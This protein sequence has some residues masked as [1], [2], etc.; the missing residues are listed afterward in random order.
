MDLPKGHKVPR[1]NVST[2]KE[3]IYTP[4][5]VNFLLQVERIIWSQPLPFPKG[6]RMSQRRNILTGGPWFINEFSSKILLVNS[7]FFILNCTY[8]KNQASNSL[9]HFY[10]N[11]L[12]TTGPKFPLYLGLQTHPFSQERTTVTNWLARSSAKLIEADVTWSWPGLW[13]KYPCEFFRQRAR[14]TS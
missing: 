8:F 2:L 5:D 3:F 6:R 13:W 7:I 14:G 12:N 11:A 9:I 4:T 1:K 10:H